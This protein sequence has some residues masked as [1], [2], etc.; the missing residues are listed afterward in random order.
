MEGLSLGG[1]WVVSEYH[2]VFSFEG[3]CLGLLLGSVQLLTH[4][5]TCTS[6]QFE[7]MTLE[8]EVV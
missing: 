3:D 2:N 5:E 6:I 1:P 7:L 4:L 8:S